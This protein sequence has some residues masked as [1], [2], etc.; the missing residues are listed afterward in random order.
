MSRWTAALLAAVCASTICLPAA[1]QWK[2]RDK[3]GQTQYS[4][5]PPPPGVSDKD[6]LAR[7][8]AQARVAPTAAAAAS[9]AS[10]ASAAASAPLA[11]KGVD[12]ELEAKR[13]LAE[14]ADVDRRKADEARLAALRADN[15]VRARDQMRTLDSG[16]RIARVNARGEREEMDDATRAEET[17]RA[18]EAIASECR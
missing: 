9:A 10:G 2:W 7:P 17:R 5:L 4:D 8:S 6:I 15:C 1:A 13:K 14:Q 3:N 16:L 18:R 11:A 12:S